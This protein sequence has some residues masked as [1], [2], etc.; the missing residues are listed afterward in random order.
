M[1]DK[2]TAINTVERYAE[3][4][5]KEF[6][7]SAIVVFGSYVNGDPHED[8]DIDVGVIFSGFTGN[9]RQTAAV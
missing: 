8:S 2:E 1:L 4:V 5:T 7:P 3:A 6:S 9:W